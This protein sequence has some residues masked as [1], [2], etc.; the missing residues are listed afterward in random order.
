MFNSK[1]R[2]VIGSRSLADLIVCERCR[3]R[4]ALL[5]YVKPLRVAAPATGWPGEG[6]RQCC[7][8]QADW[9]GWAEHIRG[10]GGMSSGISSC[11]NILWTLSHF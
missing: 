4:G 6:G 11:G 1:F 7:L 3:L 5:V 2:I 10:R 8:S 9:A